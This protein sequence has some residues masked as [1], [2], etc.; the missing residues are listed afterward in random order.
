MQR[1]FELNKIDE[2]EQARVFSNKFDVKMERLPQ[3][4][5]TSGDYIV[6]Q[7]NNDVYPLSTVVEF[8]NDKSSQRTGNLFL[9][10][11]QT[12]DNWFT[13][14]K[15]GIAL[16]TYQ[17]QLVVIKSG[18]ENFIIRNRDEFAALINKSHRTLTTRSGANGNS[19]GCYSRGHLVK[20]EHARN[21]LDSYLM[22]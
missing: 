5:G 9:E 4:P 16:A 10:C 3:G 20:R 2:V 7:T 21:L 15:S 6:V 8:K 13:R 11:E 17:N 1:F 18:K 19:H 22:E 14:K 12:S